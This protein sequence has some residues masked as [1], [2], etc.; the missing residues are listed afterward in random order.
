V[1]YQLVPFHLKP[2]ETDVNAK[3]PEP[4]EVTTDDLEICQAQLEAIVACGPTQKGLFKICVREVEGTA[5][6]DLL[7][8]W[9]SDQVFSAFNC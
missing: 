7:V 6:T 3:K 8:E 4:A 9:Q 5:F 1:I 2:I